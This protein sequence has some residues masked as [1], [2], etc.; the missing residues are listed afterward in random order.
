MK[1]FIMLFKKNNIT[2]LIYIGY[3][4][5]TELEVPFDFGYSNNRD[6]ERIYRTFPTNPY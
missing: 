5:L 4:F 3:I 2:F 1:C 6:Y